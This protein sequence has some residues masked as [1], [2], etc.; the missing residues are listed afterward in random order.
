[1]NKYLKGI[2]R[3]IKK[4]AGN[5]NGFSRFLN[6]IPSTLQAKAF[7]ENYSEKSEFKKV[8]NQTAPNPLR[9]YF[10]SHSEGLGIFKWL[11]Y[12]DV[13]HRH[14]AK[15]IGKEVN[16][17]EI[18]IFS[19]GSLE[20]W[21][22]YF[23][24]KCKIYGVDIEESCKSYESEQ[25]SIHIGNQEDRNF[26]RKFKSEV[27]N[28]DIVIDDGGHTPEQMRVT[29]EEM[30]PVLNPGGVF[31]TEDIQHDFNRFTSYAYGLIDE[32]NQLEPKPGALHEST[33][34]PFQKSVH[35]IHFYPYMMVIEK[36]LAQLERLYSEK[37]GTKWHP[38]I[39]ESI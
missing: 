35:S 36:Q 33:V 12:F 9:E 6:A 37:H 24:D 10:D 31:I 18:G 34:S 28:I 32:L 29:L 14:F 26:W 1:M 21:R 13:Y 5:P 4:G 19:G 7:A 3:L 30:L 11:H 25:I 20:M 15:F 39:G 17:L 38:F 16:I 22:S 8:S 2:N 23:G 27:G